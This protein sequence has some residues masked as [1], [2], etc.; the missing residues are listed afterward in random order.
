MSLRSANF[1]KDLLDFPEIFAP[2]LTY[3][4][5]LDQE[6]FSLESIATFL[7]APFSQMVDEFKFVTIAT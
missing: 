1:P 4:S 3:L 7:N 2:N 6:L 5:S